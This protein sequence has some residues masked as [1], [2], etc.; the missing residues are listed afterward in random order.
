MMVQVNYREYVNTHEL[1]VVKADWPS[2]LGGAWLETMQLDWR[3]WK[4][5]ICSI[6]CQGY[7]YSAPEQ[8]SQLLKIFIE[9]FL[10]SKRVWNAY[11]LLF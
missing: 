7:Y 8:D 3:L 11:H 5:Q 6:R 10:S 1:Y 4:Y 9:S 2:L